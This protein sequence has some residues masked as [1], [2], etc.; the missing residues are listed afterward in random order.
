MGRDLLPVAFVFA[1]WNLVSDGLGRRSRNMEGTFRRTGG[2]LVAPRK[3]NDSVLVRL[4]LR[5]D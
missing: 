4:C 1:S 5:I 3:P 2:D